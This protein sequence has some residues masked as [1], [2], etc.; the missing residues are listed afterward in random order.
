[1]LASFSLSMPYL[2]LFRGDTKM[3]LCPLLFVVKLM[4]LSFIVSPCVIR[5]EFEEEISLQKILESKYK[6]ERAKKCPFYDLLNFT[7]CLL[8]RFTPV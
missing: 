2:Y 1:M 3:I 7:E 5:D 8:K 4:L 6:N